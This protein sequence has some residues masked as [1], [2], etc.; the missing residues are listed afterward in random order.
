M[1]TAYSGFVGLE[2]WRD[3]DGYHQVGVYAG[4]VLKG[5]KRAD[6]PL[7]QLLIGARRHSRSPQGADT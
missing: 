5:A 7:Y 1:I 3:L 4:Q 2:L 6:L